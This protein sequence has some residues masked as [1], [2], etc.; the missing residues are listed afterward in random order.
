MKK[1]RL[2][3]W[4]GAILAA[5]SPALAGTPKPAQPVAEGIWLNPRGTVAVRTGDCAGRLCGWV[6]WA[7]PVA[8]A[9]ARDSGVDPLL[10]TELLQNYHHKGS[11]AWSGSLYVPD[12]GHRFPSTITLLG[13]SELKVE[14]CLIGGFICRSQVWQRIESLPNA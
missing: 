3:V 12:I 6:A 13:P 1:Y 11:R 10:G 7:S 4:V 9:D 14:G 2:L 8:K 5:G